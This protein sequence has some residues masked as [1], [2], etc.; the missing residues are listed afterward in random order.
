MI[1]TEKGFYQL[2]ESLEFTEKYGYALFPPGNVIEITHINK[3]KKMVC[4]PV[5]RDHWLDW[6]L[7]VIKI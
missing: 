1:I 5:L 2:T 7:P 6:D 4:G 3:C